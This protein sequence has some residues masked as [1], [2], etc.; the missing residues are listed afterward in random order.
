[1]FIEIKGVFTKHYNIIFEIP[2]D[3]IDDI[4]STAQNSLEIHAKGK[5][6]TL[7]SQH[8]RHAEEQLRRLRAPS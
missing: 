2:Y 5:A 4:A 3:Q 8:I 6:Y 1:M 7:K